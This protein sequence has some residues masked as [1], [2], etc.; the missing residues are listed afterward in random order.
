MIP[1]RDTVLIPYPGEGVTLCYQLRPLSRLSP[2]GLGAFL[3]DMQ[4]VAVVESSESVCLHSPSALPPRPRDSKRGST[5]SL[6][7]SGA[8]D[9][10]ADTSTE[11][12][13]LIPALARAATSPDIPGENATTASRSAIAYASARAAS[14]SMPDQR[15]E[16]YT[17]HVTAT[18]A[19]PKATSTRVPDP[20]VTV[21]VHVT[22]L[23]VAAMIAAGTDDNERPE[24]VGIAMWL[25][26]A[27]G[28]PLGPIAEWPARKGFSLVWNS[29]RTL[30][31]L[32]PTSDGSTPRLHVE[33]WGV[34]DDGSRNVLSSPAEFVPAKLP[35]RPTNVS[36]QRSGGVGG[37]GFGQLPPASLTLY[38]L[39]PL[40]DA[41]PTPLPPAARRCRVFFVRHGESRWNAAKRGHNVYK[42]VREHD[43]PLNEQGYRQA[44][45]LQR[46]ICHAMATP[47]SGSLSTA[48]QMAEATALW[49]SPLTRAV[50]TALV[51]LVPLLKLPNRTL[52]LKLNVRE[53]K[54]FGG[55]DSIGRV[56]GAECYLRALSEL[57]SLDENDGGPSE[58]D[59]EKL[60]GLQVDPMEVMEE[61]WNSD[62]AEDSKSLEERL[63]EFVHQL[64]HCDAERIIVVGH[65]HYYRAFF[66]RFLHPV[67]FQRD[68]GLA[69]TLQTKSVPNCSVLSCEMEFD[70]RPY[71]VVNVSEIHFSPPGAPSQKGAAGRRGGH[72]VQTSS[73]GARQRN[74]ARSEEPTP[75]NGRLPHRPPGAHGIT[76]S[77]IMQ[78]PRSGGGVMGLFKR[79]NT[80]KI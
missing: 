34:M 41:A 7:T 73:V 62:G 24:K 38:A 31:Q 8:R 28:E 32:R 1:G 29:A 65:S 9:S 59:V 52:E 79:M 25:A 39:P 43:H 18:N 66:K 57:R 33:L 61:W 15:E 47:R 63:S 13:N 16:S 76:A 58:E 5:P 49:A 2:S 74:G 22:T 12:I 67:F 14:H 56:C 70:L 55:L 68:P 26:A 51:A 27:D 50:Q 80:N 64:E 72:L 69:R 11:G 36:L 4:Q 10:E 37:A 45:E 53:K 75:Q 71:P 23:K 48:Q 60:S 20:M 3:L 54:N 19:L 17:D 42:M 6:V 30:M 78:P 21:R 35:M 77:S 44:L 46:A 40:P